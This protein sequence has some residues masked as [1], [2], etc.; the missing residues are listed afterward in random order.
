MNSSKNIYIIAISI[1]VAG[2]IIGGAVLYIGSKN[3]PNNLEADI[4]NQLPQPPD[5]T[6]VPQK[7][8]IATEGHPFIGK[9]AA[10]ITIVE[11]TDYQCPFCKKFA[12]EI[13]PKLKE[14]YI[15]TGKVKFVFRD[16][17][18]PYHPDAQK[19]A[20]AALCYYKEKGNYQD[21]YKKLFENN[22]AL[23]IDKLKTYAK[24]LGADK[25][26]FAECLDKGEF[27][28][29]VKTSF[30]EVN[31]IVQNSKI[32][33]FGTPAFFIDGKP[34]IGAQDL[35]EFEAM[36]KEKLGETATTTLETATTTNA[37]TTK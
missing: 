35:S 28:D 9:E 8:D 7:I 23:G 36:F 24:E 6:Q 27:S 4:T 3:A 32:E 26:K 11:V 5:E 31:Q 1:I 21:I 22:D 25:T 30:E 18:L 12:L 33:N 29:Q 34:L 14:K 19:A 15:D 20:E 37:T 17:P 13:F 2:I 16:F 10:P